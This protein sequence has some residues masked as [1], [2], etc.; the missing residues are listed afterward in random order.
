M[1][2]ILA[3]LACEGW[4]LR[5]ALLGDTGPL[6]DLTSGGKEPTI[7]V[8]NISFQGPVTSEND[9]PPLVSSMVFTN[10]YSFKLGV[11]EIS[12]EVFC[13]EGIGVGEGRLDNPVVVGPESSENLR[14]TIVFTSEG[15]HHLLERHV[16]GCYL[17]VRLDLK[18]DFKLD[19]YG[20]E[21]EVPVEQSVELYQEVEG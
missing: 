21:I 11:K 12:L 10:P 2:P 16:V 17:Q 13:D 8:E 15:S 1:G 6:E 20:L 5:S 19:L 3:A 18:G 7:G 4:D 9:L 14:I